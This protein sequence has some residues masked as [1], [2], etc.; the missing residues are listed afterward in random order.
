VSGLL[1]PSIGGYIKD[2]TGGYEST[3]VLSIL[4]SVAG[5]AIGLYLK[6]RLA[7]YLH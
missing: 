4:L 6:K 7:L 3:L 2:L 1:F 5:A